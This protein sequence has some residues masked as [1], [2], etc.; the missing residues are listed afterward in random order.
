MVDCMVDG[1]GTHQLGVA[2]VWWAIDN[3]TG[4][5]VGTMQTDLGCGRIGYSTSLTMFCAH[6]TDTLTMDKADD[7]QCSFGF[8]LDSSA[9]CNATKKPTTSPKASSLEH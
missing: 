1:R 6:G 2:P 9:I 4:A 7:K 8:N 3:A 5:A